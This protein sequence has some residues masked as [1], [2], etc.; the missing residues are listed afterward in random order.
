MKILKK[1]AVAFSL[2]SKIP[3]PIFDW[4]EDDLKYNL[5]FLPFVGAVI[6]I[7]S[8]SMF[9]FLNFFN[10]NL[11]TRVLLLCAVPIIITGG[12]HIDGFMDTSDAI[13]SYANKEKRLEI[14][15]DPHIGAFAV[16]GVIKLGLVFMGC[17]ALI[18]DMGSV[19]DIL[20]I[21]VMYFVS[22]A[23]CSFVSIS[24]KHAKKDGMLDMET[25][26]SNKIEK[27]VVLIE[28]ILGFAV[29]FSIDCISGAVI[30][31][32]LILYT[33]YYRNKCYMNF[34]GITGDLSGY[35]IVVTELITIIC[36][37]GVILIRCRLI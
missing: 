17:M 6:G 16:I 37:A 4:G 30:L 13:G 21:S 12:F 8:Q 34:G 9:Y 11:I 18:C 3:M 20:I 28:I 14:L 2:Y 36:I 15:K 26:A 1:I 32:A 25:K 22:R 35:Y 23:L 19:R 33:I 7:V 27:T 29:M 31:L 24:F 10:I 5:V